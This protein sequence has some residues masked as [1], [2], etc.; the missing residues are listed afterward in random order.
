[1]T[2]EHCTGTTRA[3][4]AKIQ[5]LTTVIEHA[6]S[7][8]PRP[9]AS[10]ALDIPQ[11][12]LELPD[13]EGC[14]FLQRAAHILPRHNSEV[15]AL[16]LVRP[17][18]GQ[19]PSHKVY[20]RNSSQPFTEDKLSTKKNE[21]L[22]VKAVIQ[23][24]QNCKG[25]EAVNLV[26]DVLE[27]CK[28][29]TDDPKKQPHYELCYDKILFEDHVGIFSSFL[30]N[31]NSDGTD[32]L[33]A[34]FYI[35]FMQAA[36]SD[37][38]R[39][40]NDQ[41]FSKFFK[42]D[43]PSLR[44]RPAWIDYPKFRLG[45]GQKLQRYLEAETEKFSYKKDL[46][47]KIQ[48]FLKEINGVLQEETTKLEQFW[49]PSTPTLVEA[50]H[51]MLGEYLRIYEEF[52]EQIPT[53]DDK[54]ETLFQAANAYLQLNY[55]MTQMHSLIRAYTKF[56][57]EDPKV[58]SNLGVTRVPAAKDQEFD[59][60]DVN[61]PSDKY[62]AASTNRRGTCA[63][64]WLEGLVRQADAAIRLWNTRMQYVFDVEYLASNTPAAEPLLWEQQTQ[65]KAQLEM[66]NDPQIFDQISTI[67]TQSHVKHEFDRVVHAEVII[68][69]TLCK[70]NGGKL[71]LGISRPPC[72]V[73]YQ[74]LRLINE[75]RESGLA[76]RPCES[77]ACTWPVDLPTEVP[78]DI[79][80]DTLKVLSR[81]AARTFSRYRDAIW[82]LADEEGYLHANRIR[83]P[84]I[85]SSSSDEIGDGREYVGKPI[86]FRADLAVSR[87]WLL[88]QMEEE[89][90]EDE[91]AGKL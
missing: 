74:I 22:D 55:F 83:S 9:W 63:F 27:R 60:T 88:R 73:C 6:A 68:A 41:S 44:Q 37:H 26:L 48:E 72:Y 42:N 33:K 4:R 71:L 34:A 53:A 13:H 39:R 17:L 45:H 14:R 43:P 25:S 61:E 23:K 15:V 54:S 69:A 78:E 30:Q 36:Y 32:D 70:R 21:P 56:I 46:Q 75:R 59:S 5:D 1:M 87:D 84:S 49:S 7:A 52:I 90:D 57:D 67:L 82:S 31:K 12:K 65:L 11:W 66:L 81:D 51:G 62:I 24:L 2:E 80:E 89:E 91:E 20:V 28:V 8:R 40:L 19:G 79:L 38:Q 3:I 16:G 58:I 76:C 86:K 77:S 10:R 50:V 18:R 29:P 35:Y 85:S 47:T 64:R